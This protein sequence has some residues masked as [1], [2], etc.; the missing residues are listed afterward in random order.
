M[1]Q[2]KGSAPIRPRILVVGPRPSQIGGLA[3][4]TEIL[5]SSPCIQ[6]KYKLL[7]LD[8]TRGVR[9]AGVA[10]RLALI[11][12]VYFLQQ[13]TRFVWIVIRQRPHLMHVPMTSF[14]AYWKDAAFILLAKALGMKVV[15]HLHGGLFDRYFRESPVFVQRLIGKVMR[16]ADVIIALSEKWRQFILAEVNPDTKIAVVPNTVD[17][18]FARTLDDARFEQDRTRNIVLFVGNLGRLKGVFDIIKAVP[19]VI[20]FLPDA[21]FLFAGPEEAA[22]QK[23]EIS[24]VCDD[25]GLHGVVQLLGRVTGE[26]K[27]DL[28]LKSS[29]FILPSYAENLPYSLLEAMGAGLP[30]VTTPVGAI[31]E[32]IEDGCNGFL[33]QPGDYQALASRIVDLLQNKRL[34][35]DMA[36]INRDLIRAS[37]IPEIALTRFSEIYDCL[38]GI[39]PQQTDSAM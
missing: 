11:N 17:F 8:T 14:W 26:A 1:I 19:L 5:L 9:G 7:H 29:V 20:E 16:L 23:A 3:T 30:V 37:Y 39:S 13:A 6:R 22:G 21:C 25:A 2:T 38:L 36:K 24:R 27:L 28:F 15:A 34:R 10:S 32:L 12:F 4:F 18:M 35:A 31:P 33:I